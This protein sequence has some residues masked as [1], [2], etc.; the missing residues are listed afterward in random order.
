M[1][2]KVMAAEIRYI[3]VDGKYCKLVYGQDKFVIQQSLVQLLDQLPARLF[4]RMH[5]N[6]IVN[7]KDVL[8]INLQDHEVVLQDGT[9]LAFS[10]RYM[11]ELLQAFSVL[12]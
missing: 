8:K 7:V 10:R 4:I 12:K 1:L 9:A 3:E 5:R 6:Y 2:V 11:E